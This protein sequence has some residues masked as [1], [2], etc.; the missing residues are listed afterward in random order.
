MACPRRL[1][2]SHFRHLVLPSYLAYIDVAQRLTWTITPANLHTCAR[3]PPSTEGLLLPVL[4]RKFPV[5]SIQFP[6]SE[7]GGLFVKAHRQGL[8]PL[9]QQSTQP[10]SAKFPVIFPVSGELATETGSRLT[11]PTTNHS[12]PLTSAAGIRQNTAQYS[13]SC[14]IGTGRPAAEGPSPVTMSQSYRHEDGS[15]RRSFFF[16]IRCGF[17]SHRFEDFDTVNVNDT[18]SMRF[19][20]ARAEL[21]AARSSC[22]DSQSALGRRSV[23]AAGPARRRWRV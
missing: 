18:R 22:T 1:P 13:T 12:S 7:I 23:A 20:S 3:T 9:F 17:F 8:M 19:R 5:P 10:G 11:R 2:N 21:V 6:Y 14:R 4:L 16:C 15:G